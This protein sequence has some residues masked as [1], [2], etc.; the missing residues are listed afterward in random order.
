MKKEE[1]VFIK[2]GGSLITEK[3]TPFTINWNETR[4][5]VKEIKEVVDENKRMK[6]LVGHGGGSFP[7]PIA[8][9]FETAKGFIRENSR[10]GFVLCQNAASS[11][12]RL[13]VDL[14][15]DYG[16][17]ALSIQPSACCITN[18]GDIS[19]FFA[20]PIKMCLENDIIPVVYGDCVFDTAYGCT[21]VS[22]EKILLELSK[23]I[24]PSRVLI[25][26]LV[27]GVYTDDPQRDKN[28][29][30]IQKINAN[31]EAEEFEAVEVGVSKSSSI[32]V[33]GGM[34]TKVFFAKEI[35]KMGVECEI[36]S[37]KESY[38]KK[39]L[40]GERGLGTIIE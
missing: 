31:V 20:Q 23:Y 10:R 26:T 32:D 33:T 21:I 13:L 28:V 18:N 22:T 7:H 9:F 24:K 15:I 17:N 30:F 4:R 1:K 3:S 19:N 6:L 36:L 35:T 34:Q 38:I 5:I 14:M 27:G 37:G 2:L 16:I 8:S 11:L 12:N 40:A 25:F 29:K 39:A